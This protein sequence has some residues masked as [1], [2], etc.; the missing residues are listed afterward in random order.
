MVEGKRKASWGSLP[1]FAGEGWA[2]RNNVFATDR[3]S[4]AR[5]ELVPLVI[6]PHK[7][8]E[9]FL[10]YSQLHPSAP[11]NRRACPSYP[12]TPAQLK[13][14]DPKRRRACCLN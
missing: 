11:P 9:R 10:Y 7:R 4:A 1:L 2:A 6:D 13:A 12:S 3:L 5:L 14:A 8:N